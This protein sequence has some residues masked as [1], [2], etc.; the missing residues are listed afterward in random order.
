MRSLE[1]CTYKGCS[2]L[3]LCKRSTHV[4][5]PAGDDQ[6]YLKEIELDDNYKCTS[7]LPLNRDA[8]I[9]FKIATFP[10]RDAKKFPVSEARTRGKTK[11]A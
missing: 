5:K 1:L 9:L 10:A 11:R 3:E 2:V 6:A 7:F 4:T 8:E